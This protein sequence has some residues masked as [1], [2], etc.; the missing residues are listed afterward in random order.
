MQDVLRRVLEVGGMRTK[1]VRNITDVDDKT[2]RDSVASGRTLSDF[3]SEWR[4]KYH[5]DCEGP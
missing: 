2:I 5:E 3:T 4:D 1:H